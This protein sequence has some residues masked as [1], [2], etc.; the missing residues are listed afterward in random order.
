MAVKDRAFF[1]QSTAFKL[2]K[3]VL[4]RLRL[5]SVNLYSNEHFLSIIADFYKHNM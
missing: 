5:K 1:K 4:Q 2:N 3:I